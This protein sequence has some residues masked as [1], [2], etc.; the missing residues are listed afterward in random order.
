MGKV[1]EDV[2]SLVVEAVGVLVRLQDVDSVQMWRGMLVQAEVEAVE[3]THGP[4]YVFSNPR[5]RYWEEKGRVAEEGW[6]CC[7][8]P[9]SVA[10]WKPAQR[11]LGC[12][13]VPVEREG[14]S[15]FEGF[16]CKVDRKAAEHTAR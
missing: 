6:R 2:E 14:H 3:A 1:A 13:E 11:K 10:S 8:S 5:S 4:L 7:C 9:R 16:R 12:D 15:G